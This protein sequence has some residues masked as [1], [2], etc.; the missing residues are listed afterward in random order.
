MLL[1]ALLVIVFALAVL[2]FAVLGKRDAPSIV[3]ERIVERQVVVARCTYCSA[4]TPIGSICTHGD[5]PHAVEIARRLRIR[6]ESAG[7]RVTAFAPADT[8]NHGRDSAAA[9]VIC[10]QCGAVITPLST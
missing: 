2:A 8:L 10:T 9:R 4:L 1:V 3:R 7:V 6:L 5:S